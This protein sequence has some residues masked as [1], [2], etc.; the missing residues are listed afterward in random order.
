M[1]CL[2]SL[3]EDKYHSLMIGLLFELKVFIGV[4]SH[5][6][7]VSE[8]LFPIMAAEGCDE[9]SGNGELEESSGSFNNLNKYTMHTY[10]I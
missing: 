8:T 2:F 4:L 7:D 1:N 6:N 10:V 5:V 3:D 9:L